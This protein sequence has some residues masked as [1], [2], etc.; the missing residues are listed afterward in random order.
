MAM[1]DSKSQML[2]C[3][4]VPCNEGSTT[5][6]MSSICMQTIHPATM[7]SWWMRLDRAQQQNWERYEESANHQQ[8]AERP[9]RLSVSGDKKLRLFRNVRIPD[10]HVL[11][12]PDV[13]PKYGEGQHPFPHDV[14]MLDGDDVLQVTGLTQ[15]RDHQ[16]KERHRAARRAREDVHAKHR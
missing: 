6:Y 7:Q 13:G 11:A 4:P 16:H 3:T 8:H 9:P 10:E 14:I 2:I 15:S 1:S 12:E 5:R